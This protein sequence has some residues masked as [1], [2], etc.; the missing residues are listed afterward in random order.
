MKRILTILLLIFSVVVSAQKLQ[1]KPGSI[2]GGGATGPT[3][4]TGSAGATGAT[5]VQGATGATGVTTNGSGTTINGTAVD[6]GGNLSNVET[7]LKYNPA[8]QRFSLEDTVSTYDFTVGEDGGD[9]GIATLYAKQKMI[10]I[11][12]DSLMQLGGTKG[13]YI[14]S[15]TGLIATLGVCYIEIG[16]VA[17]TNGQVLTSD[18]D[19][20]ATW[21]AASGGAFTVTDDNASNVQY[22]PVWTTGAGA[23]TPYI[24]TT[25]F[26][27]RPSSGKLAVGTNLFSEQICDVYG[28]DCGTLNYWW[29][30]VADSNARVPMHIKNS[31]KGTSAATALFIGNPDSAFMLN[32]QVYP[33][34]ASAYGSNVRGW[35]FIGAGSGMNYGGLEINTDG[36]QLRLNSNP[37]DSN[38]VIYNHLPNDGSGG[39][40][41]N[42][43]KVG[44][45]MTQP[46]HTLVVYPPTGDASVI[47]LQ[48]SISGR[49]STDGFL[50]IGDG[51]NG[52]LENKES[53][54]VKITSTLGAGINMAPNSARYLAVTSATTT[55]GFELHNTTTG[56]AAGDGFQLFA[57][58]NDALVIN[59]ENAPIYFRTQNTDRWNIDGSGHLNAAEGM[60]ISFGGTTG[61]KIGDAT[62]DKLSFWNATPIVQPANT[63]AIDDLLTNT[64]LRASGGTANFATAIS[65]TT[66]T[67]GQGAVELYPSGTYTPVDSANVNLDAASM[68][69]AQYSRAGNVVTV[70]G[71][72]TVDPTTT[73]TLTS[74]DFGLPYSS[75]IAQVYEIA[76]TAVCGASFGESAQISAVVALDKAQVTFIPT[77][78]ASM[79]YSYTF[80]YIVQ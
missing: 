14:N 5:G 61:S 8:T 74:F 42:N 46:K 63:V 25:K 60:N 79:T 66:V 13:I 26:Q 77:S 29:N 38:L 33:P 65:T 71:Q 9:L 51:V 53:G 21:Q 75:A 3:G 36:G 57:S 20:L 49:D 18:A 80:T 17:G 2:G 45:G 16:G 1:F 48:N 58:G 43:G 70:S 35:A 19:G 64:G 59:Y 52:I 32:F 54:Y 39:N 50:L 69:T 76:G 22:S 23:V 11:T 6:L 34:T 68:T 4:A 67:T 10:Q 40:P 7:L 56:T 72:F 73:L 41:N 44:I 62:T 15:D 78:T 28:A 27:F 37:Y 47:A 30:F 55:T 24:S 12:A 31:S